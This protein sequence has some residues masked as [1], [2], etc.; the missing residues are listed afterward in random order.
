MTRGNGVRLFV[1]THS[2][3][4]LL[5]RHKLFKD[6]MLRPVNNNFKNVSIW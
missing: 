5:G 3:S 6:V 1:K 2:V 4:D